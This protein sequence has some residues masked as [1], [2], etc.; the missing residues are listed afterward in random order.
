MYI[1]KEF[2]WLSVIQVY[3]EVIVRP[4]LNH[5]PAISQNY[6]KFHQ[7][8]ITSLLRQMWCFW[9]SKMR[10]ESIKHSWDGGWFI[11]DSSQG[12]MGTPERGPFKGPWSNNELQAQN[13]KRKADLQGRL[14]TFPVDASL[15]SR[16]VSGDQQLAA[17]VAV[18]PAVWK[19]RSERM[20]NCER[21]RRMH[22]VTSWGALL[23]SIRL[24]FS[25]KTWAKFDSNLLTQV[26][27]I[28]KLPAYTTHVHQPLWAQCM[29]LNL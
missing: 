28:H 10:P 23:Y 5:D 2:I 25:I 20:K 22:S 14:L 11:F 29:F 9:E 15:L 4:R 19:K 8:L 13:T 26:C 3:N 16:T 17:P 27:G 6:F 18:K 24:V 12:V 21:K 1:L 7:A